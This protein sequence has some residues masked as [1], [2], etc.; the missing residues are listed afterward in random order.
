M[1]EQTG[2][3]L[4]NSSAKISSLVRID[5]AS[6]SITT[7]L[8]KPNGANP[9]GGRH[10]C[11]TT[12]GYTYTSALFYMTG[13]SGAEAKL[14]YPMY[15]LSAT[16]N[17]YIHLVQTPP[18]LLHSTHSA[19]LSFSM[20]MRRRNNARTARRGLRKGPLPLIMSAF[21]TLLSCAFEGFALPVRHGS[22]RARHFS[23]SW[24]RSLE[25]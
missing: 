20:A 24:S 3:C 17:A 6:S 23:Q 5:H 1:L 11:V 2:K 22:V 8:S 13:R 9:A 4:L 21:A 15:A 10:K 12:G 7:I 16:A 25:R 19:S 14:P 18:S